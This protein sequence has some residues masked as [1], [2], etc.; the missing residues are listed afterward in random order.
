MDKA[1]AIIGHQNRRSRFVF[2]GAWHRGRSRVVA[3]D[4]LVA[5]ALQWAWS[6]TPPV[7]MQP[8]PLRVTRLS[9]GRRAT[10]F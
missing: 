2:E 5:Q 9:V 4:E 7:T 1:I 8:I 10:G 6:Q 3:T